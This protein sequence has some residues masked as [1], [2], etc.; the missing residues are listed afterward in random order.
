MDEIA[1]INPP[2]LGYK[3]KHRIRWYHDILPCQGK[4][5]VFALHTN[6]CFV[7]G[8]QGRARVGPVRDLGARIDGAYLLL[9]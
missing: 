1:L 6:S 5:H 2:S 3:T 7:V 9:P 4:L 8:P